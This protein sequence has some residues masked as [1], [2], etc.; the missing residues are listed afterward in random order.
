MKVLAMYLPQFHKVREN[1]LWW[2]EGF[3][4]WVSA[5]NARPLFQGHYQPH[6]PLNK[7][8]YDL[9]DKKTMQWQ[10]NLMHKYEVDGVCMYH[11][12]FK[13]GRKILEKPAEN[14]LDWKEIQ[15]PFCFCWANP[16]WARSWSGF[17]DAD[18]WSTLYEK[19]EPESR[20][21]IL[22]EQKYGT[23]RQWKEHFAYLLPFF[24]DSRY[25]TVEGSP[26]FMIYNTADITCLREMLE[27][28]RMWAREAGLPGIYVIGGRCE[29][30]TKG[31]DAQIFLEPAHGKQGILDGVPGRHTFRLQYQE[32]WQ[33]ILQ[34]QENGFRTYFSG[35]T[36]YDDTPRQG[37]AGVIIEGATPERF[38]E[39]LSE[40]MA[41]NAENGMDIVFL[42]AWNEWGEGM[43]LE[44]D[45]RYG[46]RY[47]EKIPYAK[48]TFSEK[49][50]KYVG[51]RAENRQAAA[52][53]R[54]MEK[55]ENYLKLL[56]QWMRMRENGVSLAEYLLKRGVRTVAIYGLGIFGRHLLWELAGSEIEIVAVVDQQKD[57]QHV[58]YP[59]YLPTEKIP[60]FDVMLVASWYFFDEIR[61]MFAGKKDRLLSIETLL[62]EAR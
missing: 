23:R 12:W 18:V 35:F 22:L 15:M 24:R 41:K 28:W 52:L 61:E 32:V 44:P 21:G 26:L 13:D 2:G 9:L 25:I 10:A 3:T 57:K 62:R 47:L 43:H 17:Q 37:K 54:R 31:L 39:Y 11:Y 8:Y 48:R 40:F 38:G 56:D 55:A 1:D 19:E 6:V 60:E 14:L 53:R 29:G 20:N 36:G 34:S 5:R 27:C 49:R 4:D 51:E 59:V 45:E 30:R 58:G 33:N 7:N 46:M 16:T 50:L 42:N